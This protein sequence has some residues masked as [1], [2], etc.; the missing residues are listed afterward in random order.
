MKTSSEGAVL[1]L[2]AAVVFGLLFFLRGRKRLAVAAAVGV[3]ALA[4]VAVILLNP[5]GADRGDLRSQLERSFLV[6]IQYFQATISLAAD[7]PLHGSGLGTFGIRYPQYKLP[8]AEET[9]MAHN[10]FLQLLIEGGVLA[11]LFLLAFFV[12][13]LARSSSARPFG[14]A[15]G[16][17]AS[18]V[19]FLLF[20]SL[21]AALFHN[22]IDF[23]F[24]VPAYGFGLMFVASLAGAPCGRES[25]GG[26]PWF[27]KA[28]KAFFLTA[29]LAMAFFVLQY[30][31]RALAA[32]EHSRRAAAHYAGGRYDRMMDEM[33]EAMDLDPL[34]DMYAYETARRLFSVGDYSGAEHFYGSA[35]Q[36]SPD[37]AYYHFEYAVALYM[38]DGAAGGPLRKEKIGSEIRE[39]LRLFPSKKEYREALDRMQGQGREGGP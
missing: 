34:N 1:S 17:K 30:A 8:E 33:K 14:P 4:L 27:Q 2:C 22:M 24:Y 6:R 11:P 25:E 19:A 23:D 5:G 36:K 10:I 13:A 31:V 12:M 39:A 3:A 20:V 37:K 38:A 7:T 26:S 35:L 15:E 18:A 32:S 9:Q 29:A 16:P 28:Q 21:A